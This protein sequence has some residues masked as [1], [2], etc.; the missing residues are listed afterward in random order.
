MRAHDLAVVE[1]NQ[2]LAL[3]EP[4]VGEDDV[5]W[6]TLAPQQDVLCTTD[7]V[8]GQHGVVQEGRLCMRARS[9]E[10]PPGL[11]SRWMIPFA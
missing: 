3:R 4:K 7:G 8:A 5:R 9:A 2:L 6:I 1:V 11:M 10:H